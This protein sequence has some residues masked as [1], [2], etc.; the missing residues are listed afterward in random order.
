MLEVADSKIPKNIDG[1]SFYSTLKGEINEIHE[2]IYG[3]ATNQNIQACT[4]FPSRMV[5]GQRFKLIRNYSSIE[6]LKSNLGDNSIVNKF[7][8]IGAE[9]FPNIPYEELYDLSIDPYQKNNLINDEEY[10]EIRN[11]LSKALINW[12][13]SQDDFLLTHKMPL[14]KPTL[15]PLDKQSKWN[16]LSEELQDVLNKDDLLSCIIK[17]T[18]NEEKSSSVITI[19]IILHFSNK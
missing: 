11:N 3:V 7:I 18:T 15:H 13:I 9:S 12:M 6:V 4:V 2:Y 17:N 19:I 16:N 5:R 10:H 14:I 1:K 8:K